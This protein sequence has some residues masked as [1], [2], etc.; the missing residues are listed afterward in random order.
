MFEIT[1]DTFVRIDLSLALIYLLLP[2]ILAY[3]HKVKKKVSNINITLVYYLFITVGIQGLNYSLGQIFYPTMVSKFLGWPQSPF[4]LEVG[5]AN[6]SFAILG[7]LSP[8]MERGW[9]MATGV[10]YSLFLLFTGIVHIFRISQYGI[11]YG[12][13]GGFFA[14]DL[15]L[16]FIIFTLIFK[17]RRRGM[18]NVG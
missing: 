17:A 8:W 9:Q 6:L 3:F 18:D 10:G 1:H 2:G 13:I 4:L 5:M 15:L 16:P 7:L 11:S 12:D 14:I